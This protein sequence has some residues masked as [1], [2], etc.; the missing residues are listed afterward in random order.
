MDYKKRLEGVYTD[1]SFAFFHDGPIVRGSTQ[2]HS[3]RI[4]ND[5]TNIREVFVTY[6]Q[7]ETVYTS[8]VINNK[9]TLSEADTFKFKA[10]EETTVQLKI[11]TE[12]D[13]IV[14]PIFYIEV[15]KGLDELQK[16]Y[17]D[18]FYAIDITVNKQSIRALPYSLEAIN[19]TYLK[20]KFT[21]DST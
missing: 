1:N 15:E 20:C 10:N 7:R 21:F 17:D 8:E 2:V 11:A 5:I 19:D 6:N 18:D 4:P 13:Y 12:T 9:V 16:T 3:F 14:S